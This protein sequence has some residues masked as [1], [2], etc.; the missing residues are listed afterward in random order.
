MALPFLTD[1]PL[2]WVMTVAG[3][4]GGAAIITLPITYYQDL[5]QGRPGAGAAM[6]AVQKLVA[7]VLAATAFFLGTTIGGYE[8][9]ALIGVALSVGGAALLVLADHK[10]WLYPAT[11][12]RTA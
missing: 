12:A 5:L 6:L 1:S 3:G 10:A 4:I 7:D 2:I 8:V 9:V 11:A